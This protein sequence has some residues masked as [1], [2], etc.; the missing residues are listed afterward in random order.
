[1][2]RAKSGLVMAPMTVIVIVVAIAFLLFWFG[3]ASIDF[4]SS[5][6]ASAVLTQQHVSLNMCVASFSDSCPA[7]CYSTGSGG[8]G[9]CGVVLW[10][11][12]NGCTT[13]Y[14]NAGMDTLLCG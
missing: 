10:R 4:G 5:G 2:F 11:D 13:Y 1:M 14:D 8:L 7:R 9:T 6:S 12:A 3:R